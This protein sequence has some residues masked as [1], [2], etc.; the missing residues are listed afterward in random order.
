MSEPTY[1]KVDVLPTCKNHLERAAA[2]LEEDLC[3]QC[4]RERDRK[5]RKELKKS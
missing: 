3:V 4:L 5:L 1:T 2:I